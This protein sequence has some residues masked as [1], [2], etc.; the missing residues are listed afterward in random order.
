MRLGWTG[1]EDRRDVVPEPRADALCG[2][3]ERSVWRSVV[4][5]RLADLDRA[6]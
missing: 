2:D 5:S 3:G 6:R 1:G 4:C